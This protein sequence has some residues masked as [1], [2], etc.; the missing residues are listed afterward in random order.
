MVILHRIRRFRASLP[1]QRGHPLT[2]LAGRGM[3]VSQSGYVAA[4]GFA[5]VA[6]I[7]EQRP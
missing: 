6:L 5:G 1:D 7:A 3:V 4:N 2:M